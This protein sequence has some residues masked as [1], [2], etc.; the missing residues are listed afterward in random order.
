MACSMKPIVYLA[1]I[2]TNGDYEG[3]T[4]ETGV[5]NPISMLLPTTRFTSTRWRFEL[6]SQL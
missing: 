4:P 3:G 2:T 6:L 1:T 5:F